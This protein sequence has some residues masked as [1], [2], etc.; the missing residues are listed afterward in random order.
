M[1]LKK[2]T[3]IYILRQTPTRQSK[4]Y[5]RNYCKD[6][7]KLIEFSRK[8]TYKLIINNLNNLIDGKIQ[9]TC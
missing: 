5:T 2:K 8:L 9:E 4:R 6:N 3:E 1:K 7:I